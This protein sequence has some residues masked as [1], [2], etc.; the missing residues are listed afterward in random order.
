[1]NSHRTGRRAHIL[2]SSGF[3]AAVLLATHSLGAQNGRGG[4]IAANPRIIDDLVVANRILAHEDIVDGFGHVSARSD[5]RPD[6]FILSRDLA[7]GLVS[8]G[9]LMEYDW[10]GNPVDAQGR[11][12]YSER[13]IHAAIYKVRPDVKAVVHCHT[14]SVIPFADS[15]IALRPMYHMSAFLAVGVSVFEIRRVTG[16]TGMLVSDARLGLALSQ[17]LGDKPVVLMRGHGAGCRR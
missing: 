6:R 17:S 3:V 5:Q 16:A 7:P 1:M 10:D 2:K 14:P 4:V 12:M 9:D 13:F 8:A 15:S 11:S